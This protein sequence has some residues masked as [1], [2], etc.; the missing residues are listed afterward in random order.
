MGSFGRFGRHAAVVLA[1]ATMVA[2]GAPASALA[3]PLGGA[4]GGGGHHPGSP[5]P[6]VLTVTGPFTATGQL[7]S[8]CGEFHQIVDGGGSWSALGASTFNL[9]FCIASMPTT[10]PGWPVLD[11]GTFTVTA[12]DGTL[13]GALT[14]WVDATGTPPPGGG[15]PMEFPAHLVLT[16]TAG[17]GRFAAATGSL[18]LDG[19]FGPAAASFEGTVSG[20]VTIPPPTARTVADC[21]HG[22]WRH[23]VDDHGRP[24]RSQRQCIAFVR[25]H[26]L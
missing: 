25:R 9:D 4:G 3:A 8:G 11:G 23:V 5:Q 22:G 14:G 26:R 2:L 7:L 18:V 12:A 19:I 6:E 10:E 21:K 15:I 17:S 1:A 20:T 24:F 13:S 16:I